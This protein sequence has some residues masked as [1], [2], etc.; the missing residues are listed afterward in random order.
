[1]GGACSTHY[2]EIK[3][4]MRTKFLSENLKGTYHA[5]DL[6]VDGKVIL[7]W[8]LGKYGGKMWTGCI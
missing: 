2:T 7:E 4:K 6:G 3:K 5:D 1:M 8:I